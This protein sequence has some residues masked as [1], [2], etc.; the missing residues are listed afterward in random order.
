MDL[1]EV[2]SKDFKKVTPLER[3]AKT[4]YLKGSLRKVAFKKIMKDT[5]CKEIEVHEERI[6]LRGSFKKNSALYV[7]F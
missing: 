4:E 2:H 6:D 1:F 5:L 7:P 3:R